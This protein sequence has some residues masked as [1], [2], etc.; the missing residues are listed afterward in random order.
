MKG[1]LDNEEET[2]QTLI[3]HRDGLTYIHSGDIGYMDED[4]YIYFVQRLKR[5]IVSNGYNIYPSQLENII[6]KNEYVHMSCVIGVKDPIKVQKV[7]AFIMLKKGI[8]PSEKIKKEIFEYLKKY[9]AKYSMPYDIEFRE[10][11]PTTLVGK[12][13]Y[14]KL[15][16]EEEAKQK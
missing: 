15:E 13:A 5:M 10:T 9:I 2:K 4:G 1:Y 8:E 7:K 16:E 14:R 6:D 3:K 12:V 11:L